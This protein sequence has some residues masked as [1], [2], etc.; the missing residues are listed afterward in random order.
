[1]AFNVNS[2]RSSFFSEGEPLSPAHFEVRFGLPSVFLSNNSGLKLANSQSIS[3][4]LSK[5][6]ESTSI[7][8]RETQT[9][10]RFVQGISR[11]IASGYTNS[12][13]SM[14]FIVSSHG[15]ERNIFSVWQDLITSPETSHLVS[16]YDTYTTN[17]DI[18]QYDKQGNEILKVTLIEL[19][20]VA[21]QDIELNWN[22][23]NEYMR[24]TVD[25]NYRYWVD[26]KNSELKKND[27]VDSIGKFAAANIVG[28]NLSSLTKVSLEGR[29]AG[30]VGDAL[31]VQQ[32]QISSAALSALG[33][34][35]SLNKSTIQNSMADGVPD[36]PEQLSTTGSSQQDGFLRS[37]FERLR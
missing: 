32:S 27:V 25:F 9:V 11:N 20:P 2:F 35:S 12:R 18:I 1:M 17:A 31:G 34:L 23:Q 7:P 8:G 6:C 33:A 5:R 13:I 3:E 19:Y 30:V 15:A 4:L 22:S 14:T 29:S 16:F 24:V 10:E 36:L 28:R 21:I 26:A 37:I